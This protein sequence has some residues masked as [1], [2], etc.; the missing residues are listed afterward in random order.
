MASAAILMIEAL[1]RQVLAIERLDKL[2]YDSDDSDEEVS[3][4]SDD[5]VTEWVEVSKLT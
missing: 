5:E 1:Q 2:G 3:V 4:N